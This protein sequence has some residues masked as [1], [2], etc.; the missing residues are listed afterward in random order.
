MGHDGWGDN[1]HAAHAD[2]GEVVWLEGWRGGGNRNRVGFLLLDRR[3]GLCNIEGARHRDAAEARQSRG[4]VGEE[5]VNFK[6]GRG[7]AGGVLYCSKLGNGKRLGM[8]A[9]DCWGCLLGGDVT[10][11]V[12]IGC[13][14]L[15]GF[16][17]YGM[18]RRSDCR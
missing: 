8:A 18:Y 2:L 17:V 15:W 14:N 10:S 1:G 5:K 12:T 16:V 13:K 11:S 7:K 9:T 4:G 6:R 3:R